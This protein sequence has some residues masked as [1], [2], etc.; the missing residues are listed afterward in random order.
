[1]STNLSGT[2]IT[3]KH[4]LECGNVGFCLGHCVRWVEV[5]LTDVTGVN[6]ASGSYFFVSYNWGSFAIG[7]GYLQEEA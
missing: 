4:K 6:G 5:D 3:H 2:T 1:M 7:V